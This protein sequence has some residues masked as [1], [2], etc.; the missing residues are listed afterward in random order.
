[1]SIK[2]KFDDGAEDYDKNRKYLI[3]CFD[4]FYEIAIET[5]DFKG[6]NPKVLDLGAGTGLLSKYLLEKYPNAEITLVDLADKMLNKARERF[7]DCTNFKYVNDDYLNCNFS[8]K[9]DIVIS[10]LSI[11]HLKENDKKLVYKKAYDLL[12]ENGIFLNAD[13][14]LSSSKRLDESFKN[15]IDKKILNSPLDEKYIKI[16][17]DRKKLDNPSLLTLQI[18]WLKDIGFKHVDVPYKYYIFTVIYAEK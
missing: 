1:M 4:D 7:K 12:N 16:A 13:Q 3:P 18:K 2:K 10:S 6:D 17:N 9:F 11:H 14:V 8:E 5:I 15:K